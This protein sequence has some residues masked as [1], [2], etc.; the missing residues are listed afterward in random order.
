[1]MQQSH[2]DYAV[3][4]PPGHTGIE[5][6]ALVLHRADCPVVRLQAEAGDRVLTL[7]G[8]E[9]DPDPNM[10]RCSCLTSQ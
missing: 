9:G 6:E 7:F 3:A 10:A 5:Y 4:P 1:M 8:C 2:R